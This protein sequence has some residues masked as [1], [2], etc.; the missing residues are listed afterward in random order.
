MLESNLFSISDQ[1]PLYAHSVWLISSTMADY[2]YQSAN[3]HTEVAF[4]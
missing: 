4:R 3:E 2:L 1:F